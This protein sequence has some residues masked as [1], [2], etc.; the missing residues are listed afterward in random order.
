[1]SHVIKICT[2]IVFNSLLF[3]GFDYTICVL[4]H[5]HHHHHHFFQFALVITA[6]SS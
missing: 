1:M 3:V 2:C 4:H 6:A 5:H